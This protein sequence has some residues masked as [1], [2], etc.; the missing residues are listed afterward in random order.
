MRGRGEEEAGDR[1]GNGGEV[2]GKT[3]D[4]SCTQLCPPIICT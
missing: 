1:K 3:V 2:R 4:L